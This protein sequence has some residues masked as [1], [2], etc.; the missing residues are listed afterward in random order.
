MNKVTPND[1]L[2]MLSHLIVNAETFRLP[3]PGLALGAG[4][5]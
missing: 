1:L 2:L 3:I 5:I 4:E